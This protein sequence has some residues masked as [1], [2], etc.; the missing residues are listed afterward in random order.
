MGRFKIKNSGNPTYECFVHAM[1]HP[2][3]GKLQGEVHVWAENRDHMDDLLVAFRTTLN[4]V[5]EQRHKARPIPGYQDE[6]PQEV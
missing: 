3:T 4:H 1:T 2:E 6:P 5:L